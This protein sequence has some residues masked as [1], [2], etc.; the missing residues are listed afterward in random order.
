MG[1][2]RFL[3]VAAVA[4]TLSLAA[5][6]SAAG[7]AK[8]VWLCKPGIDDNPCEVGLKTTRL[9]PTGQQIGIDRVK[10]ARRPKVDCFYV[11][12]TVSDQPGPQANLDI[13]P[14]LRS[15]ALYQ[16]ARF[17]TVCRVFAPVYRQLTLNGIGGSATAEMAEIAYQ[18]V[19]NAWRNYLRKH[20]K[21]RGVV[22][23]GHS[24]G[25][26]NL[27]ELAAEKIDP[28]K[29][30]ARKKLVSALLLGGNVTV[31]EGQDAGGDFRRI[32]AC[33]SRKQ[34]GCVVAF[35][36]FNG[37]VPANAVFGR[38]SEPGREVLCTN[39]AALGGGS[40]P[41]DTIRPSEPFAPGTIAG[42]IAALGLPTPSV[43]TPWIEYPGAFSGQCSS[44][45][46][47]NVL[48]IAGAPGAPRLNPVPPSFGL[49]LVDGNIAL[50]DLTSLVRRQAKT[51]VKKR[52]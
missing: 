12:P 33:R 42:A 16:A 39:P 23:I 35:S 28:K 22:L 30:K 9:S 14:V 25:T 40:A 4:A 37:P 21:G 8:P 17:S 34:L 6:P 47:A 51:F 43:S 11:Y 24:Q 38:T 13:D 7:A 29:R 1:R 18:D 2:V 45:D 20:N 15:I 26:F 49:H 10:A 27:I 46:D 31:A 3:I 50:G 32:R 36:T 52:G 41:L 5:L 48:Q 19:L 44:A